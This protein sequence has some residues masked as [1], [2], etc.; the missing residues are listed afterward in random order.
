M[1]NRAQTP[2]KVEGVR[3]DSAA[4]MRLFMVDLC[5]RF[6]DL[7]FVFCNGH[8]TPGAIQKLL[9]LNLTVFSFSGLSELELWA[10]NTCG[11]NAVPA[12]QMWQ[13]FG[14][15]LYSGRFCVPN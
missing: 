6:G 10:V 5:E 13:I 15:S 2:S 14:K 8:G 4:Y 11:P 12:S 3:R 9:K 7:G 1:T